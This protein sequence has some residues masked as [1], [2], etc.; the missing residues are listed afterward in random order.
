M[1]K[2]LTAAWLLILVFNT[3]IGAQ[4]DEKERPV[5]IGIFGGLNYNMH[6]PDYILP[7]SEF[8]NLRTDIPFNENTNQLSFHGGVIGNFPINN[9]FVISGRLGYNGMNGE[10]ESMI[11]DTNH[12]FDAS[13]AYFEISPVLQIHNLIGNSGLYLLAGLEFGIPVTKSYSFSEEPD[14]MTDIE[15]MDIPDASTRIA[16]M[17]GAGYDIPLGSRAFLSPEVSFRLPFSK[18]SSKDYLDEWNIS[19]FRF[20]VNL[21][22]DFFSAEEE[23]VPDE[24]MINVKMEGVYYYTPEGDRNPLTRLNVEE[25]QYTELFPFINHVFFP[26][27]NSQPAPSVQNLSMKTETGEFS[28]DMLEP[29]AVSINKHTLDILGRR[30][31]EIKNAELTITGAADSKEEKGMENLARHRAEFARDY[32][33]DNFDISP[34]RINVKITGG[35][36]E[37]PSTSND[38]DGVEE[39]RRITLS[40]SNPDLLAPIIIEDEIQRIAEPNHIEFVPKVVSSDSVKMWKLELFQGKQKLRIISGEGE[41]E[42]LSWIIFPNEL[43]ESQAPVD[44]FYFAENV[45][46]KS[47]EVS[48]TIPV[49]YVSQNR[50]ARE[51]LP[52][53]TIS[54]YSLV[55]FPF[56]KAEI[57]DADRKI[58]D[59]EVI[60][61]IKFNSTVE[62]YGYTDRIGNE[63][64]NRK[65]A[66]RRAETVR[67]Y[68]ASK[69]K[70][71]SYKAYSI[72]EDNIIFD[73]DL[74]IGRHLSRTVQIRIVTPK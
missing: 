52:D 25:I 50:K 4:N 55:L 6:T 29:D 71:K 70:A 5:T 30:M 54:K 51:D 42:E 44:Y 22:F 74:P 31:E 16:G 23:D 19:Q 66:G 49:E 27:Q 35:L 20:G 60:P 33:V 43:T 8:V 59:E 46:G 26:E 41:E 69:V 9:M 73:N 36:P 2:F 7:Q 40:S 24:S 45:K 53:K 13:L 32:L 67:D 68:L 65:L 72:G 63:S 62:I 38:P 28:V 34:L 12:I 18:V 3:G 37:N 64:Y 21:T 15:D 61:S 57:S 56:D 58:L 47:D 39:N 11:N 1:K 10:L 14:Y 17:I 48:G